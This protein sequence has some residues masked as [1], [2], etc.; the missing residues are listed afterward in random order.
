MA[1][2]G[3]GPGGAVYEIGALRALEEAVEGADVLYGLSSKGAFTQ[4]MVRKMAKN[5]IIF[6]MANPDPE[7]TPEEALAVR[8]DVLI[9]TGRSDYPSRIVAMSF[10]EPRSWTRVLSS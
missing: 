8:G 3:G 7:I 4:D 2:A 5:P 10:C 6:A 9:A 1:L